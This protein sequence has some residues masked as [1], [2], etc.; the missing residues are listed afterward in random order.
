MD[1][2]EALTA[3]AAGFVGAHLEAAIGEPGT[4]G[5]PDGAW[6]SIMR[7][8]L[9]ATVDEFNGDVHAAIGALRQ[10]LDEVTA[11]AATGEVA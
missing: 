5:G 8:I 4:V 3:M 2:W 10:G 11:S 1:T 7:D 6:R 9:T